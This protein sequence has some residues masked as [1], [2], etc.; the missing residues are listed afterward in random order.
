LLRPYQ[1]RARGISDEELDR[2]L[3]MGR[4]RASRI[5]RVTMEEV[6]TRLGLHGAHGS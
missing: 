6:K 1:E 3:E 2:I 5:A 4:E